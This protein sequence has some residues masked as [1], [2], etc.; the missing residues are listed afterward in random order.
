MNHSRSRH[1]SDRGDLQQ[2][3]ETGRPDPTGD[4]NHELVPDIQPD[5]AFKSENQQ[6]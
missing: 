6:I 4:L 1:L 2:L 5:G 3:V